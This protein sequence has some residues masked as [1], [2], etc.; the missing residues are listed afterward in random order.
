[1]FKGN[2]NTD[3]W[4]FA[5]NVELNVFWIKTPVGC[6]A[7]VFQDVWDRVADGAGH[8][9]LIWSNVSLGHSTSCL[10]VIIL[11]PF[12]EI[13]STLTHFHWSMWRF[14]FTLFY[15]IQKLCMQNTKYMKGLT[16]LC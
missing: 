13:Y 11:G 8:Y 6:R 16:L 3:L 2:K 10:V 4:V 9:D 14:N 1:M 5:T 12:L 7:Q 15:L